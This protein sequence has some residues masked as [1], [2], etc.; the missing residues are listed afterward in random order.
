MGAAAILKGLADTEPRTYLELERVTGPLGLDVAGEEW[1]GG[2]RPHFRDTKP[3]SRD[4]RRFGVFFDPFRGPG[5]DPDL[6]S[7]SM[8]LRV[9]VW[10]ARRITNDTPPWFELRGGGALESHLVW[11]EPVAERHFEPYAEDARREYLRSLP[12]ALAAITTTAHLRTAYTPPGA[13]GLSMSAQSHQARD[14]LANLIPARAPL[15]TLAADPPIDAVRLAEL[16]GMERPIASS[17]DVHQVS[18]SMR[19]GA[20]EL[21]EPNYYGVRVLMSENPQFGLWEVILHLSGRP[22][23]PLP[24]ATSGASPAYDIRQTGGD[25]VRI[26]IRAKRQLEV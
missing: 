5:P 14:E 22:P 11:Q 20:A 1:F 7:W 21:S 12:R 23:G 15:V 4:I 16:W 3:F 26:E 25:V 9:S 10:R 17:G 8:S 18:W 13:A 19:A 6:R 2:M 24:E